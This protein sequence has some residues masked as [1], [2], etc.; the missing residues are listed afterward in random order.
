MDDKKIKVEKKLLLYLYDN[1]KTV[2]QVKVNDIFKDCGLEL[3]DMRAIMLGLGH[4]GIIEPMHNHREWGE[5]DAYRGKFTLDNS[6]L[7][8]RLTENG[9]KYVKDN[10]VPWFKK[11][12]NLKWILGLIITISICI[13]GIIFK[14]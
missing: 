7:F 10:H 4:R 6:I 1:R 14:K 3:L 2:Q 5:S 8:T 11:E 13:V 9:V 12:E